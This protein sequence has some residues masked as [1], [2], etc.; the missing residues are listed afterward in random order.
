MIES[1]NLEI[2]V[3][4]LMQKV[5]DEV[6]RRHDLS[7]P[8]NAE[9][10]NFNEIAFEKNSPIETLLSQAELFSEVPT[11]LPDKFNRFPLSLS[12][13]LQKFVLKL[14][15]FLFKKQ[16]IVNFSLIQAQRE[17]TN[18]NRKLFEHVFA[19]LIDLQSQVK[20]LNERLKA[21]DER[22]TKNDSYL[23]TELTQQKRSLS[24]F[25]EEAQQRSPESV[26]Q[27]QL[28]A[29]ENEEQ[30]LLDAFY[31]AFENQFRGEREDIFNRLKVY[32]PLLEEANIGT[33]DFPILDVGCGRGEWLE[34]LRESGYTA[35]GLD[36]NRVMVD[37]CRTR[38][39]EVVE[40][41]VIAYLRTLPDLSLGAVTGFHIIEHLPFPILIKLFNEVVRVLKPG[42]LAIFETPNPKNIVVGACNF[43][44][45]PT[46][47]NPL[48]PDTIQFILESQG[49][50]KV[51]ILYLN[52]VE[53]S[54]FNQED[55]SWQLLHN[56][57]FCARDY[58]VVGYKL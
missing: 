29:V 49:L 17:S 25:L 13:G 30:H 10:N 45:D 11:E 14:Y 46:H 56:W 21:I 28:Q 33:S 50:S 38:E 4:E 24:L 22:Y 2:N 9:L 54:P 7:L 51:K 37:Y 27:G 36:H 23:K 6:A 31:T 3:D 47:K 34:L 44:A 16:R 48:F 1:N 19:Q 26:N 58:A 40:G 8:G 32:L 35:T 12:Q 52:P 15:G 53:G 42:G 43:Y 57:F 20:E 41:D 39:F 5:R 18:L 55:A